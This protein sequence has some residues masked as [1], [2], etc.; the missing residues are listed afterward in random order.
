MILCSSSHIL[1][2]KT[3]CESL[4]LVHRTR[5]RLVFFVGY[6]SF[7]YFCCMAGRYWNVSW[8]PSEPSAVPSPLGPTP[9]GTMVVI[10][11]Y[12]NLAESLTFALNG[13]IRVLF[14]FIRY[15]NDRRSVFCSLFSVLFYV[16]WA[17]PLRVVGGVNR[18]DG[19]VKTYH[20]GDHRC[21][22]YQLLTLIGLPNLLLLGLQVCVSKVGK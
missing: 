15:K 18:Q 22:R 9:H 11:K 16:C 13:M 7:L 2:C 1:K 4:T 17:S 10:L 19:E 3:I 20:H 8:V 14:T 12:K 6:V 5:Y 21:Q